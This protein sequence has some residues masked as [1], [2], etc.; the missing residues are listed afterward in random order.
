MSFTYIDPQ[1][2]LHMEILSKSAAFIP[3]ALFNAPADG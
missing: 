2:A 3:I 1:F